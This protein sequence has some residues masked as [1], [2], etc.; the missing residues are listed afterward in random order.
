MILL[1]EIPPSL[2]KVVFD[3]SFGWPKSGKDYLDASALIFSGQTYKGVAD[4]MSLGFAG[5]AVYHSG[6]RQNKVLKQGKHLIKVDLSQLPE[7]ITHIFFTLSSYKS[8]NISHFRN[9]TLRFF[10]ESKPDKML[11]PDQIKKAGKSQAIVMCSLIKQ[12]DH[13][14]VHDNGAMSS[15][16]VKDYEPLKETIVEIIE[17][18]I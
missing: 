11:C 7:E 16:N 13:W 14:Y 4:Y 10:D 8:P 6:D 12:D 18:T 2:K 9:P 1:Y 5:K 15:G 3:L 17:N